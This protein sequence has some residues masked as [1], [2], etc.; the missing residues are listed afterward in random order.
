V[1][2]SGTVAVEI[3]EFEETDLGFLRE[4]L[5]EAL[6]WRPDAE[7]YPFDMVLAHAGAVRYHDGLYARL[8][9][10]EYEPGDGNGRMLLTFS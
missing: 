6:M 5:Y 2:P 4:M 3:R 1:N 8:G 9:W 7:R 10:V